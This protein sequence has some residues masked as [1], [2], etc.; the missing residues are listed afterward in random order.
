[1]EPRGLR[2]IVMRHAK[3]EGAQTD[4]PDHGRPLT[5]RG[6]RDA[7]VIARTLATRGWTPERVLSSDSTRTRETWQGMADFLDPAPNVQFSRQLYHPSVA[8]FE[9]IVISE[10]GEARTLLTLA[11]NPGCEDVVQ[12]LTDATVVMTTANAVLLRTD[13]EHWSDAMRPGR[14][15]IVDVL[16]PRPPVS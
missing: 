4:A 12:Y 14:F 8:D 6:R 2:L 3:S 16:R 11:H 1:M 5:A 10:H 15:S 9:A 13:Q 7:P